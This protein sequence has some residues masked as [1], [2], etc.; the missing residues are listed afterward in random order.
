M[1][2]KSTVYKAHVNVADITQHKYLEKHLILALHPSETL[3]RMM[4]R[5]IA[6]SLYAD[7]KLEF[8]KGICDAAEPDLWIKDLN[9]DV[10]LW[11]DLGLPDLK[12]IKKACN[13]SDQV[14][15]FTYDDKAA[16]QWKKQNLNKLH[17]YHNLTIINIWDEVLNVVE[18][19]ISRTMTIQVNI[20]DGQ[21][22]LGLGETV[23]TI[24]PQMWKVEG[25]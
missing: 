23:I 9:D 2:Q 8:T 3:K 21:M 4:L 22:M 16:E 14:V 25:F 20:E 13:K 17:Q 5:I 12:R 19:E 15:I 6:W 10:L 11:I 18:K 1:A 24:E 7:E